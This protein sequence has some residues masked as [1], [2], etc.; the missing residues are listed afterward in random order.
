MSRPSRFVGLLWLFPLR[1]IIPEMLSEIN[2]LRSSDQ[3]GST[4]DL[5]QGTTVALGIALAARMDSE[6]V[7]VHCLIG[8]GESTGHRTERRQR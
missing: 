3:N 8:E 1:R 5:R 4:E 7:H 6:G 2:A